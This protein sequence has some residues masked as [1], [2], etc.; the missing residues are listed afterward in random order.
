[1]NS[2][3][4]MEVLYSNIIIYL[5]IL[6]S[7]YKIKAFVD[8]LELNVYLMYNNHVSLLRGCTGFDG[9]PESKDSHPQRE[10]R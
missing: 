7:Y 8:S 3:Q 1:M 10:L 4:V 2:I 5:H 6:F 9:G